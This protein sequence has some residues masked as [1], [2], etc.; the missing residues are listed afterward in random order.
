VKTGP[1]SNNPYLFVTGCT[2]SGTT[3]LQRMLDSHGLL[4][5][6]NDTHLI[7]RTLFAR[8]AG[9]MELLTPELFE[10]VTGYKRF[11]ALGIDLPTALRLGTNSKTFPG[12]VSNLLD[13]YSQLRQKPLA[14]E[15]DPEYVRRLPLIHAMF[16]HARVI[17]IIRDGR[18]VALSTLEWVTPRRYLGKLRLWGEE[19]IAV[20]ALWWRRQVTSGMQGGES[21]GDRYL[22]VRYEQ[23][24]TDTESALRAICEFLRIDFDPEMLRYHEGRTVASAGLSSKARWLPPTKG[25]RDWR[26]TLAPREAQLFEALAGDLLDT[27][28]YPLAYGPSLPPEIR[29]IAA[30]CKTVWE[31]EV[32]PSP[33]RASSPVLAF[34]PAFPL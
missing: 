20:C 23:L 19:P 17:H 2:R 32:A 29:N 14:G 21:M 5:V 26:T 3:L 6:S 7:P 33:P 11:Q 13:E 4:A 8:D 28:G 22:E 34:P 24:V 12:F 31:S 1:S 25:I 9:P 30:R 16:P 18:D 10:Q 27:L 15:K